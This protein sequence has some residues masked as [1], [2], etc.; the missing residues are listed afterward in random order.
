MS[1]YHRHIGGAKIAHESRDSESCLTE[2]SKAKLKAR[3][4]RRYLQNGGCRGESPIA[5]AFGI[6]QIAVI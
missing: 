4:R 6:L 1:P 2:A 3:R 5:Q